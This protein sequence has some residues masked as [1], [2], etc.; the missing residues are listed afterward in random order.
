MQTYIE[1]ILTEHHFL[2]S[3]FQYSSDIELYSYLCI[4]SVV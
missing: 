3:N 4:T 1:E 2:K